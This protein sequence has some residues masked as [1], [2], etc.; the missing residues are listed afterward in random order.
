MS[1][2][3]HKTKPA[4]TTGGSDVCP[5]KRKQLDLATVKSQIEQTVSYTHLTLPTIY[6]V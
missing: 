4:G 2:D 6:S 3:E 5:S 1:M